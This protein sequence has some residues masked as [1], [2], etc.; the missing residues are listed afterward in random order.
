MLE[1]INQ[2]NEEPVDEADIV[3]T[4]G[5]GAASEA[6]LALAGQL[7]KAFGGAMGATRKMVDTGHV[8]YERQ[9]GQTGKTVGP[10]LYVCC[11]VSGAVQHIVGISSSD[12]IVAIDQDA[13]AP[14]FQVADIGI[15][16]DLYDVL[17]KLI[18][19]VNQKQV[20]A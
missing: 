12:M 3:V 10:K 16:G 5:F 6:G 7:A 18:D 19:A 14:I 2:A 15:V 9:V 4:A 20:R 8:N 1:V 13:N 11:G 17:P